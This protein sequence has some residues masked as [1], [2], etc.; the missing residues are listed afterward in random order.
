MEDYFLVN[1]HQP[2]NFPIRYPNHLI[3]NYD[4]KLKIK[5]RRDAIRVSFRE[6][7][8]VCRPSAQGAGDSSSGIKKAAEGAA[9]N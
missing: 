2:Q 5:H 1:K 6:P 8:G 4:L 3:K 9:L 7:T